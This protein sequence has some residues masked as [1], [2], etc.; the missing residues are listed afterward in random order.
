M[1]ADDTPQCSTLYFG[2]PIWPPTRPECTALGVE[3]GRVVAAGADAV[4][5]SRS[6]AGDDLRTVDLAGGFLMPAFGEG[7]AHPIFGGLEAL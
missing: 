6:V 3:C 2:G 7:H 5:W 1:P 4:R